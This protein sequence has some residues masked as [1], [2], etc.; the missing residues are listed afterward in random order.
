MQVQLSENITTL[1]DRN[2]SAS[3]YAT[4]DAFLTALVEQFQEE[5]THLREE[6][7]A[8]NAML[9]RAVNE[10]DYTPS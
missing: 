7:T 5:Q 1:I 8:I 10:N 3:G 2:L 4:A 6:R 9:E